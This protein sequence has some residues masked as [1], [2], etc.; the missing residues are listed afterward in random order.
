MEVKE[1][2]LSQDTLGFI[3]S[4]NVYVYGKC[5]DESTNLYLGTGPKI[6]SVELNEYL[7][8]VRF[9]LLIVRNQT[10]VP[11][12]LER[13]NI[14]INLQGNESSKAF[15]VHLLD[16]L[17]YILMRTL[18]Y[19]VNRILFLGDVS[20]FQEN[21]EEFKKKMNHYCEVQHYSK[22]DFDDLLDFIDP[23]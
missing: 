12:Y 20:F 15:L 18:P 10:C 21:F 2:K 8:F 1:A 16:R 6:R 7:G 11:G 13:I 9:L 4:G 5:K 17:R 23:E 3:G 14:I 19:T 22:S